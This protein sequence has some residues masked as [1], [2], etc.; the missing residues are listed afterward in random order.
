MALDYFI[1]GDIIARIL[2]SPSKLFLKGLKLEYNDSNFRC[3]KMNVIYEFLGIK[4]GWQKWEVRLPIVDAI[5]PNW[6]KP[7]NTDIWTVAQIDEDLCKSSKSDS[8]S[9]TLSQGWSFQYYGLN[10]VQ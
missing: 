4:I 3:K 10:P 5:L 9:T 8:K 6:I 2:F 1:L 7:P